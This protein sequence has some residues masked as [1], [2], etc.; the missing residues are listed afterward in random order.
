[1]FEC[2]EECG[3]STE[4]SSLCYRENIV[5]V[6]ACPCHT[7]QYFTRSLF[8]ASN[9]IFGLP[10]GAGFAAPLVPDGVTVVKIDHLKAFQMQEDLYQS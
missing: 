2:L 9:R 4:C 1:M 10:E 6:D 7:G 3:A 5:C 8:L